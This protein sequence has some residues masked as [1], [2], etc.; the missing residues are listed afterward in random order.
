MMVVFVHGIFSNCSVFDWLRDQIQKEAGITKFVGYNYEFMNSIESNAVG[1]NELL[2]NTASQGEEVAIVAHS[3]GGLVSRMALLL[4]PENPPYRVKYLFML[5]TPNHGAVKLSQVKGLAALLM[6]SVQKIEPLYSRSKG[7]ND[8]T[9]VNTI[10]QKA[11]KDNE[12]RAINTKGIDYVTIPATMF[13]KDNPYLLHP[14]RD[15]KSR[16]L[17]ALAYLTRNNQLMLMEYD[18]DGIVEESSVCMVTD[19]SSDINERT[20]YANA[21]GRKLVGRNANVH[22]VHPDFQTANHIEI[23]SIPKSAEVVVGLL[24]SS[25]IDDWASKLSEKQRILMQISN[26]DAI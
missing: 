18:H 9:M 17:N 1:L 6:T 11:L 16:V 14:K 3:M 26:G 7:L 12:E 19:D 4:A 8:L 15:L 25:G 13:N 22:V 23:H 21:S 2:M 20:Y 5:G 24:K 10:F